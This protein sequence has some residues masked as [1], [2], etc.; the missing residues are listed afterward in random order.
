MIIITVAELEELEII[1]EI[2]ELRKLDARVI[3]TGVG[4]MNVVRTLRRITDRSTT[5]LNIGYA[6]SNTLEKG[7]LYQVSRCSTHH[8]LAQFDEEPVELKTYLENIESAPCY[9]SAD[10]VEKTEI[11]EPA[12]FDMELAA[13]AAM[14]FAEVMSIKKVSDTLNYQEYKEA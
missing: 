11:E 5:V 4:M 12:L 9:T 7:K 6:G 1:K 13:I 10:F 8:S 14:G 3:V 2:P